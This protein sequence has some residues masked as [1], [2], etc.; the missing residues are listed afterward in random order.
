M[1]S[2]GIPEQIKFVMDKN[3]KNPI[4]SQKNR[5]KK[6]VKKRSRNPRIIRGKKFG[7]KMKV[8]YNPNIL[9]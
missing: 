3:N 6:N 5:N 8:F 2:Q 9:P 4:L 7:N 1:N